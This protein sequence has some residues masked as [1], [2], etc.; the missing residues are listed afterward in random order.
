MSMHPSRRRFI[1]A[2][3]ATIAAP[4]LAAPRARAA[5]K[6]P[7]CLPWIPHGGYAFAFAAK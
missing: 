7:F 5:T 4:L 6:V 1:A 3:G 2:A